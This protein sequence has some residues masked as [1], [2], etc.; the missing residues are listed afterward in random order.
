MPFGEQLKHYRRAKRIEQTELA[1]QLQVS[2]DSIMVLENR[3]IKFPNLEL[4][5]NII[6]ILGI[7]DKIVLPDYINFLMDN[8]SKK[9]KAF[10]EKKKLSHNEFARLLDLDRSNLRKWIN[11][12][13]QISVKG[14]EK[15]KKVGVV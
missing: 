9:I 4:L 6:D 12:Q 13:V 8:P 1:E 3:E 5:N 10:K 2:R 11:G 7:R 15:L 14:Y